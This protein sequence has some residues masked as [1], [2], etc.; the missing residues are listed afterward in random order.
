M[1]DRIVDA[2]ENAIWEGFQNQP[3]GYVSREYDTIDCSYF[4]MRSIAEHVA[5][6][7]STLHV[8]ETVEQL[9]AIEPTDNAM[10]GAL[11][12][13]WGHQAMGDVYEQNN[14]GTWGILVTPGGNEDP[15]LGQVKPEDMEFLLPAILLWEPPA[16]IG[17]NA[18]SQQ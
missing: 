2:I 6:R 15:I 8:I 13:C 18:P 14:D 11:I 1:T 16:N 4:D 7:L 10:N 3:R 12:K 17:D 9:A 5:Q